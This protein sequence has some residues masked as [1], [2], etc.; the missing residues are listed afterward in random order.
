MDEIREKLVNKVAELCGAN[1]KDIRDETDLS[2]DLGMKSATMVV[3]IAYLEE[4]L[5]IDIDFMLFS[6]AG[7]LGGAVEYLDHLCND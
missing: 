7:T 6:K 4:D 3:L 1:A 2:K 5:D